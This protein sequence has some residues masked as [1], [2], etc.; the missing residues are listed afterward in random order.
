M[1]R[2]DF[3]GHPLW[4]ALNQAEELSDSVRAL[5]FPEDL[6]PLSRVATQA[7]YARSFRPMAG[8]RVEFF[9][10]AMLDNV[11]NVWDQVVATLQSRLNNPN[12]TAIS[13]QAATQAESALMHMAP[14]PR[15]YGRGGEVTQMETVF[16]DLLEAQRKAIEALNQNHKSLESEVETFRADVKNASAEATNHMADLSRSAADALST[17]ESQK[18]RIDEVVKSGLNAVSEVKRENQASWDT[19][20]ADR[21][22]EFAERFDPFQKGI[23]QDLEEAQSM[24]ATLRAKHHEYDRLVGAIAADEIASDFKK[25]SRWGRITGIV[26]Y[27]FGFLFLA[28]AAVPLALLLTDPTVEEG[29]APNWGKIVV[30]VSIGVLA[31]SAATIA[32]RLGGRLITNANGAKRME[33]EMRSVGPFLANVD[34][35]AEVDKTLLQLVDR[36]FGKVYGESPRSDEKDETIPLSLL[37]Q[38]GNFLSKIK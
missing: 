20:S 2:S 8:T 18:Q 10:P 13:E 24:L 31:G 4:S 38:L 1:L 34:E 11:R 28:A 32:F 35:K 33:L 37:T 19:W 29:G 5:G 17:V 16:Q 30:R 3:E 23:E 15:H 27:V 12:N 26:F 9:T 6:A 7:A 36:A 21:E 25:E 22:A 14:W